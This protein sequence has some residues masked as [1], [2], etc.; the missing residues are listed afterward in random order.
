MGIISMMVMEMKKKDTRSRS[1]CA[2]SMRSR[3]A[4]RWRLALQS[5]LNH[6]KIPLV[7]RWTPSLQSS[8]FTNCPQ[9]KMLKCVP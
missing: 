5:S 7:Q 6:R 1:C 2:V 8:R 3:L 4:Q 9:L